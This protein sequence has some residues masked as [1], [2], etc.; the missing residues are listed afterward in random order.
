MMAA[1]FKLLLDSVPA[2]QALYDELI[3]LEVEENADLPGAMQLTLP[4]SAAQGDLTYVNDMFKPLSQV[5]VVVTPDNG[6]PQCIFDGY[7]LSQRLHLEQGTVSSRLEVWGQ[8]ASWL[9]NMEEKVQEW[10]D[11]TDAQIAESIF[12]RYGI[13]AAP[14][15]SKDD[16]PAHDEQGNSMMQRGTDIGFLR[17]LAQSTGKLCRVVCTDQPGAA[18]G[19]FAPPTLDAKPVLTL[20]LNDPETW[21]AGPLDLEWDVTRPTAVRAKQIFLDDPDSEVDFA[22]SDLSPLDARALGG[23][24]GQ[25]TTVL[26]SPPAGSAGELTLRAQALLRESGWFARCEGESD[27]ARLKA[28]LRVGT[29]VSVQGI[30]TLYAGNYLVW[31]VRHNITPDSHKMSFV[32]VRNAAGPAPTTG[33][34]LTE[35][36]GGL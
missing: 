1:A 9:M 15:N 18:I 13:T 12:A 7:V 16:S 33:A 25:A 11:V 24:T 5:A 20:D 2:Q 21:N 4:V 19:Y 36:L 30:G 6:S 28:V 35:L 34:G 3:S 31:S 23:F 22:Q 14:E 10:A 8:D 26:L 32:L 27:M 29:I 17:G